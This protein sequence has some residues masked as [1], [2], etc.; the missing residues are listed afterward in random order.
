MY[1]KL[2][3][4]LTLP[5]LLAGCGASA[6]QADPAAG[7][8]KSESSAAVGSLIPSAEETETRDM[9]TAPAEAP[10][11]SDGGAENIHCFFLQRSNHTQTAENEIP[12]LYE[13]RCHPEFTASDPDLELWVDTVLEGIHRDYVTRSDNLAHY[14]SEQ[15]Q[16]AG[17]SDFYAFSNYQDIGVTRHDDRLVSLIVLNS[18]YSGGIHPNSVQTAWNLDLENRKVLT[19]ED[20]LIPGTEQALAELVCDRVEERF[21]VLGES[22]LFPDY[23]Q[24]ISA[25]FVP[26]AMTPYWY[27]NDNG[28]V[29][30][31]NQYTLG[32]YASGIIS[33]DIP[34]KALDGILLEEFKKEGLDYAC[35]ELMILD[36]LSGRRTYPVT[37]EPGP[38]E[39]RIGVE[40]EVTQ[41]RLSEV[42]WL[43][44]TAIGQKMLFSANRLTGR[45]AVI[46]LGDFS[47]PERSFAAEYRTA[48]EE[49]KVTYIHRDGLTQTP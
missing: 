46:L 45:D 47:D 39:I 24:T 2:A 25:A 29:V 1:K 17:Q 21:A 35:G 3:F 11:E 40:G 14:A 18:V 7:Y 16:S 19:L 15:L 30:F 13:Y 27:F 23:A 8:A 37:V 33:A 6:D 44:G 20:I 42:F 38:D 22:A 31:F 9:A 49:T 12:I 32:P 34:Y 4:L 43:E 28:L 10:A 41:F 48:G 5:L 36:D 26:G